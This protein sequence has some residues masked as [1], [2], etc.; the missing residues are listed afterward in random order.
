[1]Y[2]LE[3]FSEDRPRIVVQHH[4]FVPKHFLKTDCD[5]IKLLAAK[6]YAAG[7]SCVTFRLVYVR[8]VQGKFS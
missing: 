3:P 7:A 8:V 1:M 2:K 6:H 4:S 5:M